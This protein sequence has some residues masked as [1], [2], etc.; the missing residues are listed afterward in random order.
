MSDTTCPVFRP[1]LSE[2]EGGF[3]AY[4]ESI[5]AVAASKGICK[6]IPPEG[7]WPDHQRPCAPSPSCPPADR[8]ARYGGDSTGRGEGSATLDDMEVQQHHSCL[9]VAVFL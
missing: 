7:W 9:S 1:T 8:A 2:F 5:S 4:V 3:E 6:V